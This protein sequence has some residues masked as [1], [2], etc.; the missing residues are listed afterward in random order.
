[1]M[2]SN[3]YDKTFVCTY[4]ELD[5]DDLY[6]SQ[7]LQAFKLKKWD[8]SKITNKTDILFEIVKDELKDIFHIFKSKNTRFTH[9]M[10]FMGENAT[11]DSNLFR[12]LFTY[13]LFYLT[14][15][16]IIDIIDNN[17]TKLQ[18]IQRLKEVICL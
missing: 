14:H 18:H 13:D 17:K 12:I 2:P 1:M 5:S 10:L 3:I 16:C 7:F 4:P 11:E 9:L 15:R 6:R 8:D